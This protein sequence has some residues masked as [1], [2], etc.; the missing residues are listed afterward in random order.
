MMQKVEPKRGDEGES[1]QGKVHK[2]GERKGGILEEQK[3]GKKQ[4][5]K[6]SRIRL[7]GETGK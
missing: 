5:K 4:R 2:A 1:H 3:M 7:N 6:S